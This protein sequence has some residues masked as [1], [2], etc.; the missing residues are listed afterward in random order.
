MEY[1]STHVEIRGVP[2]YVAAWSA[3][4]LPGFTLKVLERW[5]RNF[6]SLPAEF[7]LVAC[8]QVEINA[9]GGLPSRVRELTD[10]RVRILHFTGCHKPY[11]VILLIGEEADARRAEIQSLLAWSEGYQVVMAAGTVQLNFIEA[12]EET[13][14]EHRFEQ[15][16][17]AGE[18][19]FTVH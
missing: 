4:G 15:T 19:N 5:Q 8:P 18:E 17:E 1:I 7:T 11:Q 16:A 10:S 3:V 6:G 13:A 12:I 14:E 2:P 9:I